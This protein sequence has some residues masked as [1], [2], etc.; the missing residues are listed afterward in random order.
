M[1]VYNWI[2]VEMTL[3]GNL[4]ELLLQHAGLLKGRVCNK[5]WRTIWFV[6]IWSLSLHRNELL[7][8]QG[9]LRFEKV[10]ELIKIRNLDL[11]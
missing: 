2:G 1:F 10:T 9:S 7:F 11:V 5:V 8:K 6:I 3:N 4:K